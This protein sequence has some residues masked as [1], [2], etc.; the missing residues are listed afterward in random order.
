MA[1]T[2]LLSFLVEETLK[3]QQ[4]GEDELSSLELK[5]KDYDLAYLKGEFI[6]QIQMLRF[7]LKGV[8]LDIPVNWSIFDLNHAGVEHLILTSAN[9]P[10]KLFAVFKKIW[11]T[12]LEKMLITH[13]DGFCYMVGLKA[14]DDAHLHDLIN[15]QEWLKKTA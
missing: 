8:V 14:G 5:L 13:A 3:L 6:P 1:Q 11:L 4:T 9:D 7:R 15:P 2:D 12:H 10:E